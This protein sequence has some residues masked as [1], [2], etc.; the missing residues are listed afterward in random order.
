MFKL[1]LFDCY[2]RWN[3]ACDESETG[4][5]PIYI[6]YRDGIQFI[7]N[8]ALEIKIGMMQCKDNGARRVVAFL[9]GYGRIEI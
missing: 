1:L 3:Y 7:V 9:F 4:K 5:F 6:D 2:E 8:L